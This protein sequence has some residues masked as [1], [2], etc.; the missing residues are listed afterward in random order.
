VKEIILLIIAITPGLGVAVFIY[1]KDKYDPE[2]IRTLVMSF[3]MGIMAFGLTMGLSIFFEPFTQFDRTD[4]VQQIFK[5]FF[6]VAFIE[7]LSKFFFLR[8]L[9]YYH[10]DFDEPLDGIIYSVMIGMGFATAENILYIFYAGGG[11]TTA[12]VR[13]F[14]AIPAHG[15]FAILL[16]YFIGRAKFAPTTHEKLFSIVGLL[17]AVLFHGTYDYFLFISYMPKVWIW[18]FVSL[19]VAFLISGKVIQLLQRKSPFKDNS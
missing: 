7:E 4:L 13:M 19:F 10:K 18:S 8:G 2:P 11:G 17:I 15:C 5:A 12:I 9:L 14:T 3:V 16:G 6:I 1:I